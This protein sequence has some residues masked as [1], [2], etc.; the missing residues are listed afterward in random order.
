MN[1][2]LI[3]SLAAR[4][5][6]RNTKRTLITS[7]AVVAGV[8]V[9]IIGWGL[10]DG[11]DENVIRAQEDTISGH[12]L[13]RPDQYPDD[14]R[15][16][17]IADTQVPTDAL[18][19]HLQSKE[20]ESW[21]ER[22]VFSA[23]ASLFAPADPSRVTGSGSQGLPVKGIGYATEGEN[24]VFDR[25][26]WTVTGA[27]PESSEDVAMGST[28]AQMMD[29]QLNDTISLQARAK[30]QNADDSDGQGAQMADFYRVSG[31]IE[32]RNPAMDSTT[33]W[34]PMA[35]ADA[36]LLTHGA[37]SHIAVRLSNRDQANTFAA[38]ELDGWQATTATEEVSDLLAINAFRRRAISMVVFILLAI[39]GTGIANTVV[40]AAY[41]RVR[42]IGTL[43]AMGMS[44]N[45]IRGLFLLEGGIMGLTAGLLGAILGSG[46]VLHFAQNGIDLSGLAQASGAMNFSTILYMRFNAEVVGWALAFGVGVS[47]L[48]SIYPAQH[49]ARMNPADAVRAD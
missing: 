48:A 4:N 19:N 44:R 36:L 16:Y 23:K 34:L 39:A 10:V 8:A 28:L 9:L 5:L 3:L 41:E 33:V 37:R 47:L 43:Q 21:T 35:E 25:Q 11:L 46:V 40:M 32:T 18:K 6:F 29:V 31:I 2:S 13:L 20:V 45:G 27:W 49:A 42:E 12:V 17:P 26:S 38:S 1:G 7:V 14:N 30:A 24:Q 15:S 22:L